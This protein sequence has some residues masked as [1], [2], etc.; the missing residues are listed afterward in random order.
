MEKFCRHFGEKISE[1]IDQLY[2]TLKVIKVCVLITESKNQ[3]EN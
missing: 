1:E 3:L 2:L